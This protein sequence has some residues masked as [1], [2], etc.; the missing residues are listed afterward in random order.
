MAS[1]ARTSVL[2]VIDGFFGAPW[3]ESDIES[4]S[5]GALKELGYQVENFYDNWSPPAIDG[6]KYRSYGGG[7]SIVQPGNPGMPFLS[8]SLLYSDEIV[9]HCPLDEWVCR[10]RGTFRAPGPYRSNNPQLSVQPLPSADANQGSF[11]GSDHAENLA[12]ILAAT[13]RLKRFEKPIREGW[14]I[15]VPH[16]R[17]WKSSEEKIWSQIRRDVLDLDVHDILNREW[18]GMPAVS[19]YIRGLQVTPNAGWHPADAAK[20]VVEPPSLYFNRTL[21]IGS[22]VE[23]RFTPCADVDLA[24]LMNKFKQATTL[25]RELRDALLV[26]ALDGYAIPNFDEQDILEICRIRKSDEA[27]DEWRAELSRLVSGKSIPTSADLGEVESQLSEAIKQMVSDLR[28][29]VKNDRSLS[30]RAA[31]ARMEFIDIGFLGVA[32]FLPEKLALAAALPPILK[33]AVQMLISPAGGAG[34]VLLKVDQAGLLNGAR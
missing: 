21:A 22:L 14:I 4:L 15:P 20:A 27:F 12:K 17:L 26:K 28:R 13:G 32:A 23:S 3:S 10:R 29:K 16:L 25:N 24:L 7:A 11:A 8:S 2:D 1:T 31:R 33:M 5:D 19:D 6:V 18:V 34:S 30:A 9:M